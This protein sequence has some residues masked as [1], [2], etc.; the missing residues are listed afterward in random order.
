MSQ[1]WFFI[2][3]AKNEYIRSDGNGNYRSSL[4]DDNPRFIVW[5]MMNDWYG[6]NVIAAEEANIPG[7]Y[8]TVLDGV[9]KT[10]DYRKLFSMD[11]NNSNNCI[12][13]NSIISKLWNK[14][15]LFIHRCIE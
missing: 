13:H 12:I 11:G 1:D 15:C 8:R 5:V 3:M 4:C 6:D 14:I 7:G 9:E 10:D 2:N